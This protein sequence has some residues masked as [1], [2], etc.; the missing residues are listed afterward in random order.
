M[1]ATPIPRTLSMTLYG[2]LEVSLIDELPPG[3]K[4]VKTVWRSDS[5]RLKVIGFVKEQINLGRQIY[6]VFPLIKESE[7]LDYKNLMDGFESLNRDFPFTRLS[8]F[9]GS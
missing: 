8:G 2:D 6:I 7:K 4:E 9:G 1:T 5:N 3:R